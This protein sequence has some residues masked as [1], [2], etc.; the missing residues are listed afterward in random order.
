MGKR[1]NKKT[2]LEEIH[3]ERA[4]LEAV[5]A[6]LSPR[7]ISKRG[8]NDADWSIKDVLTHLFDW[9]DRLIDW[10]E[11]GK[12]DSQPSL[13]GEGYKWSDIRKLNEQIRR[14][15]Q[16]KSVATV[17]ERFAEVHDRTLQAIDG[18]NDGEL[19][20]IGHYPWTG[21]S[22]TLSDYLRANT[23]SHYK[24]ATVKIRKWLNAEAKG[25]CGP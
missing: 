23:A 18:M 11:Q 10:Y 13:P 19:T 3:F 17:L 21:K 1:L 15:H 20:T 4:K 25:N 5:I 14:K 16:R 2:L 6:S 9:E 8:R 24:W 7:Q 12:T 22:W